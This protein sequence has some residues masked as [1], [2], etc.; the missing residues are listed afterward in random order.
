[1]IRRERLEATRKDG[2]VF[3]EH[4]PSGDGTYTCDEPVNTFVDICRGEKVFN[5]ADG[6]IGLRAV[7]VLDA[8]YRSAQT[9]KMEEI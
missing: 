9:G 5:P 8:M 7:E 2:R 4:I 6:T 3:K 1:L